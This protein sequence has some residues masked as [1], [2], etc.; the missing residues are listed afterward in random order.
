MDL[1]TLTREEYL[2]IPDDERPH[3]Y[4]G[5]E[6]SNSTYTGTKNQ[7]GC[8]CVSCR[9]AHANAVRKNRQV[10][11]VEPESVTDEPIPV[12]VPDDGPQPA[13]ETRTGP[14]GVAA[15]PQPQAAVYSPPGELTAEEV[16]VRVLKTAAKEA[17]RN[18]FVR[19]WVR[20]EEHT[21]ELQSPC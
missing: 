3:L 5:R 16:A 7:P 13:Q 20:S 2:A 8:R 21:S 4:P 11:Q 17:E 10:I 12:Q 6:P 18:G 1:H 19:G 15:H 9:A 14:A